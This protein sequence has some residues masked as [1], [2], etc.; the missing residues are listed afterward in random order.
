MRL[1]R[2]ERDPLPGRRRQPGN[3][4]AVDVE[5]DPLDAGRSGCD[6][7]GSSG[8]SPRKRRSP[9]SIDS[10]AAASIEP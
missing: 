5:L 3:R 7:A 1:S 4:V 9:S 2:D 8:I 10:I 6:Y